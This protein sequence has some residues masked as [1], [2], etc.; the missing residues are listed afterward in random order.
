MVF[1][2]KIKKTL[3][4]EYT[5]DGLQRIGSTEVLT[6]VVQGK[7]ASDLEERM[8]RAW[9]KLKVG[10]WF[11]ERISSLALGERR[12]TQAMANLPGELEIDQLVDLNPITPVMED[13]EISHFMTPYQRLQDEERTAA[14]NDFGR[15]LGWREVVRIPFT[16]IKTQEE[17]DGVARRIQNGT[18]IPTGAR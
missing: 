10:Y 15:K 16:E 18:Y 2:Y 7:S 8:C 13:G 12:L 17:A 4:P 5:P 11:R 14:I 6:G 1:K 9:D 3:P